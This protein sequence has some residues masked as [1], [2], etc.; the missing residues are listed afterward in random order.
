MPIR[1]ADG[2]VRDV[3]LQCAAF[4]ARL[5]EDTTIDVSTGDSRGFQPPRW[6]SGRSPYLPFGTHAYNANWQETA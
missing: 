3:N 6:G 5:S 2:A 1:Y 4:R